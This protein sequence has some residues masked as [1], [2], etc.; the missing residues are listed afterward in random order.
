MQ[1]TI[2][3][4]AD[5][6][7]PIRSDTRGQLVY[8][9]FEAEPDILAIAVVDE[10]GRP[11]GLI[12]RNAFFVAMAAHYGRALYALRPI[13]L[14]MNRSPLVV[15]GDVTVAE[16]CGQA[17]AERASELLRGFIVTNGGRYAGVG[18]ALS[19]LQATSEANRRHAEEMTRIADTLGRAEAQAQAALSAK[20]QFL[21]V[22][23][24]E[25]RTPLNG[26][27]AIA[28]I[29]ERKLA[30]PELAPYIQTIQDS[31]QTLL[32]LLTDAL[33]LSRAEAGRLELSEEP[34]DLPRLLDDV[35][36]LW[37]A[38]AE[39]K[40]LSLAFSYD[41]P[42]DQWALGDAVR[43]KQVLNNLISNALKFTNSGGIEVALSCVRQ[44]MLLDVEGVV[45]DTGCGVPP[46][47]LAQ[48]FQPFSQTEDGVRQ[49]GAGLGLSICQQLVT[50]MGGGIEARRNPGQGSTF[51]FHIPLYDVPP[52][53]A[54]QTAGEGDEVSPRAFRVLIAD[55]N[56]T[57]RLVAATLCEM[58]GG[59]AHAVEDGEA[60]VAAA[61]GGAFDIIL[62][63]IKMPRLDGVA[64]TRLIRAGGGPTAGVPIIAL[65]ANADPWDAATYLA[66]GM[67]A[68]VEKPIKAERLYETM[69]R[70]LDAP[71]A[72]PA[73][74]AA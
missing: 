64:A 13:S 5:P 69:F 11:I 29:L 70:L 9:R 56:A 37:S 74:I 22:M 10:E 44:D 18:S 40:G 15:E 16:F 1:A 50:R 71:A 12:E 27:L 25:I 41:G 39:E 53:D 34:F 31:G 49:G 42:S 67:N 30:Q 65:T 19:L 36:S 14:L 55:D 54:L 3:D 21:A 33:D 26:V 58:V 51:R 47:R 52:G 28:D 46:D 57:N 68:V 60:A 66:E 48:I 62:M 43:I 35:R 6:A 23:S 73:V 72:P 20:S 17:L 45:R 63:D 32:R 7:P 2:F 24:H 8:D 59:E 4:L 61:A 38:R